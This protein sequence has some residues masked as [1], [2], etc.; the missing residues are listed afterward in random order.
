MALNPIRLGTGKI[1]EGVSSVYQ[2]VAEFYPAGTD[3]RTL[4]GVVGR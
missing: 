1:V 2:S 4:T 3:G